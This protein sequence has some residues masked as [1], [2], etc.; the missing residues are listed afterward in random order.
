MCFFYTYL[1]QLEI[2]YHLFLSFDFYR[3][4]SGLN[5]LNWC[6]FPENH[7]LRKYRLDFFNFL[8]P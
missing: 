8:T 2:H 3:C 5:G 7:K 1:I 4:K 6:F